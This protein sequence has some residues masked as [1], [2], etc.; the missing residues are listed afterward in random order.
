MDCIDCHNRPSHDFL[1]SPERAV[2]AALARGEIPA[3]LP[4][5]RRETVAALKETYPDRETAD[6]QNRGKAA[7][8]LS[9]KR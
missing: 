6:Q 8:V 1:A 7:R 2:D 3:A 4:F 9:P 5:V